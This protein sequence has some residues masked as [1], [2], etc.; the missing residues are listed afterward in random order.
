MTL[1]YVNK[2]VSL[3]QAIVCVSLN[4]S[5]SSIVFGINLGRHPD[6]DIVLRVAHHLLGTATD[7]G[8]V[9]RHNISLLQ[10][11]LSLIWKPTNK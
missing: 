6:E 7:R 9:D 11:N 8:R 4:Y 1:T 10:Y 5:Y 2:L 3:I